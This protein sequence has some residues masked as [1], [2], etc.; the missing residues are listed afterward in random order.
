[1]KKERKISKENYGYEKFK[2]KPPI[3]CLV[4]GSLSF[5]IGFHYGNVAVM[6]FAIICIIAFTY[7]VINKK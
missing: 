3:L 2:E 4:W 7:L 5:P 1:M 6:A